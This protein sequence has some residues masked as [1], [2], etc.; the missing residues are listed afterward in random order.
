MNKWVINIRFFRP[1]VGSGP[2]SASTAV[3]LPLVLI[4]LFAAVGVIHAQENFE[5]FRITDVAV[6]FEGVDRNVSASEQFRSIAADT[7]GTQYSAVRIRDAIDKLYQT[8]QIA[9]IV[10]EA[11]PDLPGAVRLRFTIK[12]KVQA[13][14]V[15]VEVASDSDDVTEQELL[16]KLNLLEAGTAITEQTLKNNA[17]VILDYL[18]DRGFFKAEV[19]YSQRPLESQTEVGVVFRVTPG[20]QAVVDSFKILIEGFDNTRLA[21]E[22]TLTP[23]AKYSREQ[24]TK[25]VDKVREIL[26]EDDYLAPRLNEPRTVYDRAQNKVTLELTGVRGPKVE[27]IV[28]AE[29]DR[30]GKGTQQKLLPVKS[31]GTLDYAAIIEGERRL[32]NHYQEQGYFFVNVKAVCSVEPPLVEGEATTIANDT[33]FL[34][35]ALSSAELAN[36]SVQ[37]KYQVDLN[38]Q[39]KLVDI[40]LRGADELP[41]E[42]VK[43]VL[44]SQEANILGIIPLFGYGRG[45]TSERILDEDASTIRSLL[46]ELGYRD[47]TVRVNQGVSPDGTDIIITFVADKGPRTIISGVEITGNSTFSDDVLAAKLPA[48][49]GTY[50]SRAKIRNGQR[51]IAEF[52]SQEGYFDTIVD[53]SVDELTPP[54]GSTEKLFKV[55]YQIKHRVDPFSAEAAVRGEAGLQVEGEGKRFF[56]DRILVTGNERTRTNAVLRALTLRTGEVLRASDIYTSEQ[57]LYASDAFLQVTIKPRAVGDRPDGGRLIDLIINVEEQPPRILSYG[58]GFSTDLGLSGFADIRHFNLL[59][60]LWQGGARVRLSQ[61]QQLAQIDF[62]NPRFV[63]DG[64]KRYAPL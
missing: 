1:S 30:V 2:G 19:A 14:R 46:R 7:V 35:S 39:L 63:K 31:E 41:I 32:E 61:R 48:L 21:D 58:G 15:S 18:R 43:T 23:G 25:D 3:Y 6:A 45:Y 59:G 40:R 4:I 24:L 28:E 20:E 8:K 44:E 53:Y 10:V 62:V 5:N 27:V 57:N 33:E 52:Y 37:L 38:R 9:S 50:F 12:R 49:T 60:R 13:Q 55:V 29:R 64:D 22:V 47:A 36:K 34:C 42:E 56:I 54:A 17:D 11:T 51:K 26:R 16:L